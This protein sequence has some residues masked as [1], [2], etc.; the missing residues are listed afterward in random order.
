MY[1]L[2]ILRKIEDE[3]EMRARDGM[4][5]HLGYVH[6]FDPT[7]GHRQIL[8]FPTKKRA[9]EYYDMNNPGGDDEPL[10]ALNAHGTWRSDW[11][12]VTKLA[13]AVREDHQV[14]AQ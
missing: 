8:R 2:E 4:Y 13:Y 11:H 12:P 7:T 3:D 9:A 14:V 1:C 5:E 6:C 10:R